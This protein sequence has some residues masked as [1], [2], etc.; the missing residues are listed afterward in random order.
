MKAPSDLFSNLNLCSQGASGVVVLLGCVRAAG[1]TLEID[2]FKDVFRGWPVAEL[3]GGSSIFQGEFG[4]G[5]GFELML[6]TEGSR[7]AV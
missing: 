3:P 6:E 1:S 5:S 7:K 2:P 4:N